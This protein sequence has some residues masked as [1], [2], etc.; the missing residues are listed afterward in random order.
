MFSMS[1]VFPMR[2][3]PNSPKVAASLLVGDRMITSFDLVGHVDAPADDSP[4]ELH[5]RP[6]LPLRFFVYRNEPLDTQSCRLTRG[7]HKIRSKP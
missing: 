5:G 1:L 2:V 3:V 7:R 4:A 6:A